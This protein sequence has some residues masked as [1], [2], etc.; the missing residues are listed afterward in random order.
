MCMHI[1]HVTHI[2]VWIT[3]VDLWNKPQPFDAKYVYM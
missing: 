2:D 3:T 1:L